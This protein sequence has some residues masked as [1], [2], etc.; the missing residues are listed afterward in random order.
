MALSGQSVGVQTSPEVLTG[1]GGYRS[2]DSNNS[3]ES[4]AYGWGQGSGTSARTSV[5]Y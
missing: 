5:S 3:N 4:Q 2:S 1:E